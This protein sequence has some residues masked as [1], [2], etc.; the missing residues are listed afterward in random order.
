MS[1]VPAS[2]STWDNPGGPNTRY[3]LANQDYELRAEIDIS[4]EGVALRVYTDGGR[5]LTV[6]RADCEDP[7]ETAFQTMLALSD[8]VRS[9]WLSE[10]RKYTE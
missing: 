7:D 9:L 6:F 1:K 8:V 2:G 10:C 3:Q 4:G 5:L